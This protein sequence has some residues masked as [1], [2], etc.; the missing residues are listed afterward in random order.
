MV[1][2]CRREAVWVQR[3]RQNF[4]TWRSADCARACSQRLPTLQVWPLRYAI[5][6]QWQSEVASCSS[7]RSEGTGNIYLSIVPYTVPTDFG[8]SDQNTERIRL[9]TKSGFDPFILFWGFGLICCLP[10]F[11]SSCCPPERATQSKKHIIFL[12]LFCWP[13]NSLCV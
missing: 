6:L 10:S 1:F 11:P 13:L 9:F 2:C 4:C 12:I 3:V 8:E 7:H 5:H